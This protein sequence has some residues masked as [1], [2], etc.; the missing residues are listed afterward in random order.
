VGGSWWQH[1]LE[2]KGLTQGEYFHYLVKVVLSISQAGGV[3]VGRGA[4]MI[5]GPEL[6]FR[7]RIVGSPERCAERIAEREGINLEQASQRLVEV[8]SE[9][10]EYI[11]NLYGAD[12]ADTGHYDLVLNSDRYSTEQMVEMILH[13]MQQSGYVL[14][15][16]LAFTP[17]KGV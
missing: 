13:A 11:C 12:I 17:A 5:L 15:Q 10:A 14:P 2:K 4:H 8:N 6:C 9:R 16:E 1:L 7:V 3:I